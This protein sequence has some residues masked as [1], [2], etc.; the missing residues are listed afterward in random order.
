MNRT[1]LTLLAAASAIAL[2]GCVPSTYGYGN[3]GGYGSSRYGSASP[4]GS[5][6]PYGGTSPYGS[7]YPYG[8]SRYPYGSGSYSSRPTYGSDGTFRCE[9]NDMR[10]ARCLVDTRGGVRLVRQDSDAPCIQGR[11][12]GYDRDGV[13]VSNGCRARFTVGSYGYSNPGSQYS[14]R[15]AQVIR[16]ESQDGR[17]DVCGLPFRA[18]SVALSRQLSDTT[19][20]QGTNWGWSGDTVWVDNGCR[21]EFVARY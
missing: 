21:A 15:D 18:R 5:T 16:C 3:Y 1:T 8:S 9:S 17:R 6:Y 2:A 13:W 20:R 12:W 11:T 10:V 4:Y 14:G 7:P 19:C